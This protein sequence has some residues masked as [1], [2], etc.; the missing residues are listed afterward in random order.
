[1]ALPLQAERP[2]DADQTDTESHSA[3]VTCA[4]LV[5]AA[6]ELRESPLVG[7]LEAALSSDDRVR[8]L[9]RAEIARVLEEHA[10]NLARGG[11]DAKSYRDWGRLLLARLLVL[12]RA[13]KADQQTVL[14]VSFVETRHG[15]RLTH[16]GERLKDKFARIAVLPEA[17]GAIYQLDLVDGTITRDT[18]INQSYPAT[19]WLQRPVEENR[20]RRRMAAALAE[21]E[22]GRGN[23]PACAQK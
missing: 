3:S 8:L 16:G 5:D 19:Y 2:Y 15:L 13:Q 6:H 18:G 9:E 20:R 22:R 10:L 21:V 17:G 4:L 11:G 12:M 7:L 1:M 14:E 23:R